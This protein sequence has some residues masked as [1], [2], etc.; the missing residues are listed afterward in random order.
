[1]PSASRITARFS[2]SA[3]ICRPIALT[4]S[5]GGRMS[6]IST[7]VIL[8]PQALGRLI[9]HR[10]QPGVDLVALG[11]GLVEVH[12][13]H[14]RAQIGG[15]ELHDR[16][17]EIADLVGGLGRVEHLE[18]DD[19]VDRDH[20]IVLGDDLLA[21]DVEHLLHHVHLAADAVEEGGVEVEAGAGDSGEAAEMLDRVLIA[22]ADDLHAGEQPNLRT[23][24]GWR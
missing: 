20:G 9:D 14:H 23:R 5:A 21:G 6:L 13:A 17:I 18:E 19:A 4:M 15:R 3:F 24:P 1:M 7:R 22:L 10:Q 16:E 12:R 11:Q 2:R 8:T